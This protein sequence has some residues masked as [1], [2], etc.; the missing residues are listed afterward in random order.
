MTLGNCA[1]MCASALEPNI[2]TSALQEDMRTLVS[3]LNTTAWA[4]CPDITT[5]INSQRV[6]FGTAKFT[7][8]QQAKKYF[9]SENFSRRT[10]GSFWPGPK[11]GT[12]PPSGNSTPHLWLQLSIG[13]SQCP[14]GQTQLGLPLG[15]PLVS[16]RLVALEQLQG[17]AEATTELIP[18]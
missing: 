16:T 10:R 9:P 4:S 18:A 3:G 1:S 11:S 2:G 6:S 5:L 12:P 15:R 14:T 8:K 13:L 7:R 17:C